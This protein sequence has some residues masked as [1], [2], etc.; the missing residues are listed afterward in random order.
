[1]V[2]HPPIVNCFNLVVELHPSRKQNRASSWLDI[3]Y[4]ASGGNR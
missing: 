2:A 3:L 1:M 4:G